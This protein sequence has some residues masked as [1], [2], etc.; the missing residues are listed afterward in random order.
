MITA[1]GLSS[2]GG[3]SKSPSVSV[4]ASATTVDATDTVTLTAAVTNDKN[5]G[6]VTWTVSG[7]GTLSGTTTTAA[8]YTAPAAT[9][10][11]QTVT[12]T[13]T[14]VADT[15]KTGSVTLTVPAKL[16][17]T[18]ASS[19][20]AGAVGT[21]YSVQLA[22]SGGI[23]PY[24]WT[25]TSGT[26][27]T[28]WTL[29]TGGLLSGPAPTSGQAG[30]LD[31]TF[32]VTDSGTPTAMTASS[33]LTVTISPAP[34]ITFTNSSLSAGTYNAPY[35]DIVKATGG[36][37]TL[38]Y[39]LVSG[40]LPPGINTL[41]ANSGEV[42][43]TPT[44]VGTF[45]FTIQA[46]DAFGDSATQAYSITISYSAVTITPA[47][48]S[49]PVG[50]T[51]TAYSQALTAT[52]GSGTGYTWT[53]TGL[54]DGLTSSASGATL[55]ISGSITTAGAVS[56][57]AKV[58]DSASNVST[59]YSYTITV[60]NPLALPAANPS[61]LPSEATVN[62]A[63][64]G[65]VVA[66][67]GSGNYTWTVTGLSG[68]LTSSTSGGTLTISGTLTATGKIT[69]TAKVTDTTTTKTAGPITYTITVNNALTLP[70]TNPSTLPSFATVG[71]NY[72]G[73]VVAS[74]GSGHY[75]W[76][77]TGASDGL[78]SSTS[79][80]TLTISGTP[81][82]TGTVTFD[83]TLTDTSTSKSVGPMKYTIT[84]YESLTLPAANPSTL[85]SFATVN[86][87]Y[88]G[89][90]V[91]S[92][93]SGNYTWTVTGLSDGLTSS[94][95]G[96]T[97]TISG[98]PT[99]AGAISFNAT[100]TDTTTT[101]TA[102][103]I[104]YTITASSALTLPTTNP[105]TLPSLATV[106]VNYAGT[107]V[108]SGGSGNYSWTVTGLSDGLTSS[109][110]GGTLTISGKP[111][112]TG[113][114][115]FDATVK[116]TTT[117]KTV[118]PIQYTITAYN[119]LAVTAASL[120]IGYPGTAYPATSFAATGGS[121]TYTKWVW[122]ATNG[123]ALPSGLSLS[124]TTGAISGTPVNTG[125]SSVVSDLT[126][127]VTDS[128]GETAFAT[129][130]LTIEAKL[131]IS[132]TS[133][134]PTGLK[135][136]AYS[137]QFHATGGAGSYTW[138][139][140]GASDATNLAA[141]GLTF[142]GSGLLSATSAVAGG[143]VT[144]TAQVSDGTH[145]V[146]GAFSVT[147]S[148]S[149]AI[150][151]TTLPAAGLAGSSY[152]ATLLAS[153]GSGTYT[154][155][156]TTGASSL[157]AIGLSLNSSTGVLSGTL[158]AGTAS[159]TVTVTDANNS[160][161]KA[162]QSYSIKVDPQL[163]LTPNPNPLPAFTSGQVYNGT[164][165]VSGGSG[166]YAAS[167]Q[168]ND[169]SGWQTVPPYQGGQLALSSGFSLA[170]QN[171][172]ELVIG[173]TPTIATALSLG[174][175]VTD[176]LSNVIT[177]TF[178]L[179]PAAPAL[180]VTLNE[181]PQGMVGMPYTYNGVS[182]SGGTGTYTITY[183]KTPAGLANGTSADNDASFLVGIPTASGTTTVTVTVKDS[184]STTVVKTFS[185]TVVPETVAAHDSYLK[186]Q[187]AC[188]IRKYWDGGVTG[189]NKTSTLFQGG[190]VLA[191]AVDGKG[192]ITNGEMDMNSPYSGYASASTL[193]SL[194]GTYAVGADNRGYLLF[195]VGS[196]G[197]G[198]LALAG[199][200]L[201][202]NSQFSEFA[203]TEMD[204]AGTDPSGQHGGGYCYLQDTTTAFT[205]TRPSGSSA[206]VLT[207]EDIDGEPESIVG[208]AS[209][210]GSG[211]SGLQDVVDYA[212]VTAD[213]SVTGTSTTADSFGRLTMTAGPSGQTANTT[214][215]Y[216]TNNAKGQ[217]LLM[218]TQAHN[219]SNDADFLLGEARAQVSA[220][221]TASYPFSGAGMLYAE[222][223][224]NASG[225]KATV[226]QFTGSSTAAKIAVNSSIINSA[227]TFKLDA[228]T[229]NG[230][231][232]GSTLP[233]KV[234]TAT[235]R[236]TL[237]GASGVYFY[238]YNT[239]S[240]AV[241]FADLNKSGT[242]RNNMV[243]WIEP[244]TA[245][246]SGTWAISDLATSYFMYKI[247]NWNYNDDSQTSVLTADSSG[248]MGDFADDDGGWNW[249]SWDEGMMDK[250]GTAETGAVALDTT[251]GTYGLL[252]VNFTESGTT[253]TQSYCFAI[254]VD[255]ATKSG[256][257][258]KLVCLDVSSESP[259][260][261]F[262]QE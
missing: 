22:G 97:L 7:G 54:S 51:G 44:K 243:G 211:V 171:T 232:T 55:T 215:M 157:S 41:G 193:G 185:L 104:T 25:L 13:A 165:T 207:G 39:S 85:P 47:S 213:M 114:V 121:G 98:T 240:A 234:D 259:R 106:G 4:T 40:T 15:S 88:T 261:T 102:G 251:D 91:A 50:Y 182:V 48:G 244:Q 136:T 201:N 26:L 141:L 148:A 124:Q 175:K 180:T 152:T 179:S 90:V 195:T 125:T 61:T 21:V 10:S 128:A 176:S 76:A 155:S 145:T 248:N 81:T 65:T 258:G 236:T 192:N 68:G 113:K 161:L 168:V 241:L 220:V 6:G 223:S 16:T 173:G 216:L 84:A 120:P 82:A 18:T 198:V 66:T 134:L 64:T 101:K 160:S 196:S 242:G 187:Y 109:T 226:D 119:Q 36:A 57:T 183:S 14:S 9:S 138:T 149:I 151:T 87:A 2:C 129:F 150:T 63:Y 33:A 188:Y 210:S 62:V 59:V 164:I 100:V 200:N 99:A 250:N 32:L 28:G 131:A 94:T 199:G 153:G 189:G 86:V 115:T 23:A 225:Y 92:G 170:M 154:W 249:A 239:N 1:L 127:T 77:I 219:G 8:T 147:I 93:G 140:T 212:T 235:G 24:K 143:P 246:T 222:G 35:L 29:T 123:T 252:D 103:P 221:L 38:T 159:F 43:G 209:F 79:G 231:V 194:G 191:I 245:P 217:A 203:I 83:V 177:Q 49:L 19:Q 60:Y 89:T 146:S 158:I 172:N 37:G 167:F 174:V 256:A 56:F 122:A 67:G 178:T 247:E 255:A 144:F 237:T 186:G 162:T 96:G 202:S 105:S 224:N 230:G 12:V 163:V 112:A 142:D 95:S 257:K 205:G 17:V 229:A 58:T 214:V 53:V 227:G 3:S 238:L 228:T 118:G 110:S 262:I 181:V 260:L 20:L 80:G 190:A 254:S 70:A 5:S 108:A 253:T 130:T 34:A 116:D 72:T 218:S 78:T 197:S 139:L 73:T 42:L 166:S 206:F 69:F 52:G 117:N 11:A 74:G 184:A 137:Q 204:D 126:V 233:Y 27:P 46:A 30:T 156:V 169:G 133:P 31:F 107:V 111:T 75:S 45:P 135:G 208:S 71:V 132:T